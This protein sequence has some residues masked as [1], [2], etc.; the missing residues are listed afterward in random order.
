MTQER[1]IVIRPLCKHCRLKPISRERA[2][3][4]SKA[5]SNSSR[6]VPL[7]DRFL[8]YYHP[9]RPDACWLWTGTRDRD[10]YGVIGDE[11]RRQVRAHRIAYERVYGAVPPE[12]YVLHRCD[13]PPCCNPAHLFLGTNADNM[14]DKT[15]KGRHSHGAIHARSKLTDDDVRTIRG[16]YPQM[17]QAAI[18]KRYDMDQSTISNIVL[19]RIWRHI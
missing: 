8:L 6:L 12:R 4:C 18:A 7:A 10:G 14:A 16:L 17:T 13:N 5:C 15:A 2:A 1:P 11:T 3:Y 19:R 9:G